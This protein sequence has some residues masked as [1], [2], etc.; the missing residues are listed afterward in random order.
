MYFKYFVFVILTFNRF[1]C[2]AVNEEQ[3]YLQKRLRANGFPQAFINKALQ[4]FD[5]SKSGQ[6]LKLN[7]LGFLLNPDYRPHTSD[8][9]TKKCKVFIVE[10]NEAFSLAE[11]QYGVKKEIIASLL[12]VESRLGENHGRYH[13]ASV[14]LS[15]LLGQQNEAQKNLLS[16]AQKMGGR[17][18][19]FLVSKIKKR[20]GIKSRWAIGELWALYKMDKQNSKVLSE[21]RGSYSGAFGYS[22]FLPSSFVL[23]AKSFK[24]QGAPDLY[25]P[26]DAILSVANYLR[27][28]GYRKGKEKSYKKSLYMYNKSND[29][30]EAI[31]K[32]AATING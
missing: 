26:K 21:L 25:N 22:Q 31:L 20:A 30:G 10:N 4:S 2:F 28:N 9:G 18:N 32:L 7:I 27:Q 3:S 16:E 15:L 5:S 24:S 6:I 17:V 14:Y 8:E 29:Y 19:K 13:V 1:Y 12:W 11:N 23:W